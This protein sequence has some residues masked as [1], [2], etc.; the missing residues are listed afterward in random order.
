MANFA[1]A[2]PRPLLTDCN[3]I[4]FMG[5]GGRCDQWRQVS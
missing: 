5:L 1:H 4:S 3:Q 2:Q